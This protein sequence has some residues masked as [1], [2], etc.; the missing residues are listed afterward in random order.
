MTRNVALI[1]VTVVFTLVTT[2]VAAQGALT[3]TP[4]AAPQWGSGWCDFSTPVRFAKG[5]RLRLAVGGSAMKIIV[6][7][8]PMSGKGKEDTPIGVI[9][10]PYAVPQS[11]LVEV[12]VPHDTSGIIQ[13]SV[14][15]GPNPW[16]Q[17]PLG[18]GNGPAT[19]T[20]VERL[21]GTSDRGH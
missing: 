18:A 15:G 10:V 8:L 11:R 14:H 4:G 13:I 21:P 1:L 20:G 2:Q 6:R 5:E 16:N 12:V 9:P 3:C 7:F 19:L 17:Y